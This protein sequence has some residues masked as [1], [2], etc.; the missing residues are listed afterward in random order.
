MSDEGYI[1]EF[2]DH[3]TPAGRSGKTIKVMLRIPQDNEIEKELIDLRGERVKVNMEIET[4][5]KFKVGFEADYWHK[6]KK[7][8]DQNQLVLELTSYYDKKLEKELVDLKFH[9]VRVEFVKIQQGLNEDG[10]DD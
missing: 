4:D 10:C 7:L 8:K 9:D 2:F 1:L 6:T 5:D 3:K